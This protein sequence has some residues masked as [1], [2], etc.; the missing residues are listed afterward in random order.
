MTS[1]AIDLVGQPLKNFHL[2]QTV[3]TEPYDKKKKQVLGNWYIG[4]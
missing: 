3:F 4:N 2:P 1:V